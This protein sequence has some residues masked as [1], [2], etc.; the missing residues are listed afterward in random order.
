MNRYIFVI[1][2]ACVFTACVGTKSLTNIESSTKSDILEL[3]N[4]NSPDV[5]WFSAQLKGQARFNTSSYPISAQIRMRYDSLIWISVSGPLGIEAIRISVSPDSIKLINRMNNTYFA[6]DVKSTTNRFNLFLSYSEIQNLLLGGYLFYNQNS[7]K[8]LR[9]N[10][11]YI[12]FA[13][14]DNTSCT[15]HLNDDYLPS[16]IIAITEDSISIKLNYTNFLK[17]QDEWVPKNTQLQVFSPST[18]LDIMYSYS[19]ILINRPKKIKFSIPSTYV[20][21]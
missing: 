19:K 9:S 5:D 16:E 6:E 10:N 11:D 1:L 21:L 8:L 3:V 2:I 13:N 20:P 14:S 15:L 18:S 17:V 7:F 4:I 12:L